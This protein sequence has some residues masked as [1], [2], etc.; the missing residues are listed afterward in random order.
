MRRVKMQFDSNSVRGYNPRMKQKIFLIYLFALHIA[1]IILFTRTNL[2]L[3]LGISDLATPAHIATMREIH[4]FRE[5]TVPEG[6]AIFLGDSITDRLSTAAVAPNSV[7]F[8]ISWQTSGQLLEAMPKTAL[9]RAGSVY[10]LIG[11]NDFSKGKAAGI[12][13][14]LTAI[15]GAIPDKPLLWTGI[16][17]PQAGHANQTIRRLCAARSHCT[18]VPPLQAPGDF[19]DGVHLTPIGYQ[20]WIAALK[21]AH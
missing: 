7:N 2:A 19:I 13:E 11:A 9:A 18:Y 20:H 4:S 15:S 1:F 3:K 12:D 6:A 16:M 17:R 10:L 21:A 5:E 8:G 14:T